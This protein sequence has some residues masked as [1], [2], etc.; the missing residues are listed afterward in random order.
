MTSFRI[1]KKVVAALLSVGVLAGGLMVP[2]ES[3]AQAACA[4]NGATVSLEVK[5]QNERRVGG[6]DVKLTIDCL[7]SGKTAD[8]TSTCPP[9]EANC[10]PQ[11]FRNL[12]SGTYC[13]RGGV[14]AS[15]TGGGGHSI[16]GSPSSPGGGGCPPNQGSQN[17]MNNA[18]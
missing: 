7:P 16:G 1:S 8:F 14:L 9:G 2:T 15:T 4:A 12:R 13:L 6:C 17:C 11:T 18:Q 5:P 10:T 3:R